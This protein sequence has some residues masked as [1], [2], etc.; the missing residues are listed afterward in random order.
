MK[1]IH[2]DQKLGE[3]KVK[4]DVLDDLWHLEKVILEG[5]E[6]EAHTFRT[7]K[8]GKTEEKK[9]VTIRVK[10]ERVEFANSPRPR[11]GSGYWGP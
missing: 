4:A 2:F 7:Y 3:M 1:I 6:V 8:V 10:V 9:A 5:D 11:T